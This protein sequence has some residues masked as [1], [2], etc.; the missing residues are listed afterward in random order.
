MHWNILIFVLGIISCVYAFPYA[1]WEKKQEN[2]AGSVAV[3]L[4]AILG[5][6]L[7]MLQIFL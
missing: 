2:K 6:I 1:N 4:I 7:S 3:G 5:I